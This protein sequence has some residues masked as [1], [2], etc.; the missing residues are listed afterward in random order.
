M[1]SKPSALTQ[2]NLEFCISVRIFCERHKISLRTVAQMAN[3]ARFSKSE[4][5]RLVRAECTNETVSRVHPILPKA[6]AAYLRDHHGMNDTEVD[7]E[8]SQ[9]FDPKE[10]IKMIANRFTVSP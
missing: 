3:G 8:M 4:A 1:A 7:A 6:F 2:E 10:Y 9:L 5:G